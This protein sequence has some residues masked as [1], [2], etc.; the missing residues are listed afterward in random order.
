M[1]WRAQ[2]DSR[3]DSLALEWNARALSQ[4]SVHE[5]A[6]LSLVKIFFDRLSD[7]PMDQSHKFARNS[8]A[9]LQASTFS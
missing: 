8:F 7:R 3:L 2:S 4:A 5:R 1:E 6:N 9:L